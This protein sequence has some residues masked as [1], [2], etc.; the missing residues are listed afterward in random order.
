MNDRSS[1]TEEKVE[2]FLEHVDAITD[3]TDT[4][5]EEWEDYSERWGVA[6]QESLAHESVEPDRETE[7]G[8]PTVSVDRDD[9]RERWILED[10]GGDW[11]HVYKHGW[12]R[13]IDG[14]DVLEHRPDDKEA[15]RIGF[16][17]R[18]GSNRDQ[19]LIDRDLVFNFRCMGSN[20]SA[21]SDIYKDHFDAEIDCVRSSLEGTNATITGNKLT[22]V[23]ATYPI[24]V[25]AHETYFDAYTAALNDAF[26]DLVVERPELVSLFTDLFEDSLD[27]YS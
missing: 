8:Y 14:S 10:S 26:V 19:A 2:L 20:P 13:N 18:M 22:L 15:L 4:F 7:A 6:M 3:V 17:H 25:D 1:T 16:Y 9:D 11:Q 5:Q 23:S 12:V 24:D 21:F 27:A